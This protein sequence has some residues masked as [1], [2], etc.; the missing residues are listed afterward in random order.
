MKTL[1]TFILLVLLFVICWP[2]AILTLL[3]WPLFWLLSIPFRIVGTLMEAILATVKSIL[4]LPA[5][6]LGHK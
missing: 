6:I 2:L 1:L 3:L 5:R 4:F